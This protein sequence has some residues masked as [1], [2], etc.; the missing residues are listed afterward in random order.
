[1]KSL[2]TSAS[3][4]MLVAGTAMPLPAAAAT[5]NWPTSVVGSYAVQANIFT[6]ITLTIT[7]QNG[8]GQCKLIKGSIVDPQNGANDAINGIYCH[9]SGRIAFLRH[10]GFTKDIY[11]SWIGNLSQTQSPQLMGGTFF[12]VGNVLGEY[13]WFGTANK[14]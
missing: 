9:G 7:H 3:L 5:G 1:M 6:D 14:Q 13:E 2:L 12:D 4:L 10:A 11:Q 8:F